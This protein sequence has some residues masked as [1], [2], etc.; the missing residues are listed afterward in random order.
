MTLSR[1]GR[2]KGG[3]TKATP[4]EKPPPK[5][6]APP[7]PKVPKEKAPPKPRQP[8][9]TSASPR[10][11]AVKAPPSDERRSSP[12][13]EEKVQQT[14]E[15][16]RLLKQISKQPI[17]S[18]LP[19]PSPFP[20]SH[21]SDSNRISQPPQSPHFR[22]G[23]QTSPQYFPSPGAPQ[24]P[25]APST[26]PQPQNVPV[27][28]P[29]HP[30]A[31]GGTTPP[32]ILTPPFVPPQSPNPSLPPLMPRALQMYQQ[33]SASRGGMIPGMLQQPNTGM[34]PQIPNLATNRF[35]MPQCNFKPLLFFLKFLVTQGGQGLMYPQ[36]GLL[37]P[38]QGAFGGQPIPGGMQGS[39]IQ[40]PP[41]PSPVVPPVL[42]QPS[43]LTNPPP[44]VVQQQT[45]TTQGATSELPPLEL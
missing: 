19:E 36:A 15:Q 13:A 4:K 45:V 21:T 29:Q 22:A 28:A 20:R 40:L 9:G 38:H 7:K 27:A 14:P 10:V 17:H 24:Y 1:Q 30:S 42:L 16:I 31:P 39:P 44:P 5:P 8:K 32:A 37:S 12:L 26:T 35:I 2:K 11:V 33:F 18:G 3:P 25:G 6:K 41:P 43:G 23:T 34:L